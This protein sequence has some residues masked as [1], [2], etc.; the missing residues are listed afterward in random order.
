MKLTYISFVLIMLLSF[1]GNLLH[2]ADTASGAWMTDFK[3]AQAKAEAEGK[4]LFIDFTGSDWCHW[5][6]KLDEEVL[7]QDEFMSEAQKNFVFVLLDFPN[8]TQ[9]DAATKAQNEELKNRYGIQGFP[10]ILL[11]DDA[12]VVYGKTGYQKGGPAAYLKHMEGFRTA[13]AERAKAL[14]S[15]KALEGDEKLKKLNE[16]L[17][18][19]AKSGIQDGLDNIVTEMRELDPEDKHGFIAQYEV[20]QKIGQIM[21]SLRGPQD[22]DNGITKLEAL[23]KTVNNKELKQVIFETIGNIYM[24]GKNDAVQGK[25]YFEKAV[26]VDPE[27]EISQQLKKMLA[28]PAIP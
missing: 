13:K 3:A 28:A 19:M 1:A 20:P 22:I 27:S 26:A 8:K 6:I 12:G 2:A 9:L 25:A 23:E 17:Q 16:L 10:T 21:G 14:E 15:I 5:C 7:S 11:T 18:N 4:D 24:R